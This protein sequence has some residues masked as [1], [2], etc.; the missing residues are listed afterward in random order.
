MHNKGTK[1]NYCQKS[2]TTVSVQK[3]TTTR[4]KLEQAYKNP[5][6]QKSSSTTPTI[7]S[8]QKETSAKNPQQQV[9][10]KTITSI[11]KSGTPK[12]IN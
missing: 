2:T 5:R 7:A 6:S 9:Y 1:N 4:N 10:K 8:V 12:K 3:T 11:E